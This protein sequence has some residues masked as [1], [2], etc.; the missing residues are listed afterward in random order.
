MT[1]D[2]DKTT[3]ATSKD[4]SAQ[5]SKAAAGARRKN[6]VTS[7]IRASPSPKSNGGASKSGG[8]LVHGGRER[9]SSVGSRSVGSQPSTTKQSAKFK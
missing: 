5:S 3:S 6:S 1:L 4:A 7:S 8:I 9:A 2:K